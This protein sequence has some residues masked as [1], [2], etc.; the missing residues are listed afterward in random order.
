MEK[1]INILAFNLPHPHVHL[2]NQLSFLEFQLVK[3]YNSHCKLLIKCH[4]Y[5]EAV[6]ALPETTIHYCKK[7]IFFLLYFFKSNVECV[8]ALTG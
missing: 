5:D 7:K 2:Y 8:Y 4:N 6:S 1:A 3:I